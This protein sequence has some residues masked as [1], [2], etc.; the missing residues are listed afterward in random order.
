[1]EIVSCEHPKRVYN[2][3]IDEYVW[4]SCGKCNACRKRRASKWV[5]RLERERMCRKYS[6]FVTLTYDEKNLPILQFDSSGDLLVDSSRNFSI[7]FNELIFSTVADRQYFD[8]RMALRGIPYA[9]V[10]DIQKFHKRLNKWFHDNVT[11]NYK[12]FRY[13]TVSEFGSTTLRPHF[14]SIYFTDSDEVAANFAQGIS[15]CWKFGIN[16]CQFVEKSANSYVAQYLNELFDLPSFYGHSKIRPFFVCSKQPPIGGDL[17]NPTEFEEIFKNTRLTILRPKSA[18]STEVDSVPLQSC[19]ENRIFPRCK[20]FGRISHSLRI[21]I[22]RLACQGFGSFISFEYFKWN[23]YY[24]VRHASDIVNKSMLDVDKYLSLICDFSEKGINCLKRLYY[25]SKRVINFCISWRVS[26]DYYVTKIEEYWSKK[27]LYVLSQFYRFQSSLDNQEELIHCYP[28][29]AYQAELNGIDVLPLLECSSYQ[30]FVADNAYSVEKVT[31][32]HFKNA[33]FD[34]LR[35]K[36]SPLFNVLLTYY[37]AKKCDEI[38]QTFG[39]SCP[40]FV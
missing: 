21:S 12:N 29:F 28:E 38:T 39:I 4:T 20:A 22:Y 30:R 40:K 24:R 1:M 18:S 27:E 2:K 19:V 23:I 25:M 10:T 37:Y 14:H 11:Q 16:D 35:D 17:Y 26:I 9:S 7:P 15:A 36:D 33:Y 32:S 34:S 5:A 6:F 31:K 8:K 3:Y 13:F